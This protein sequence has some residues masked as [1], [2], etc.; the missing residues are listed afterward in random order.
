MSNNSAVRVALAH[1]AAWTEITNSV[2][3]DLVKRI[4]ASDLR[5]GQQARARARSEAIEAGNEADSVAVFLDIEFH[6]ADDA[7]TARREFSAS[8]APTVPSSIRYVG[9]ATGLA[10]LIADVKAADV[11]DGVILIP[12]GTQNHPF[13]KVVDGVLPWLEQRGVGF[14][15]DA[16]AS[17]T[18]IL[19]AS[20]VL[21]S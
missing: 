16:V 3:T 15:S 9:T 14:A 5:E 13:D 19:P 10:G 21:A 11:A 20:R 1:S 18:G 7:R 8:D 6:I 17:V 2:P 4:Q 12:V